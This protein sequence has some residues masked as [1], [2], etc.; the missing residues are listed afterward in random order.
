MR[1]TAVVEKNGD[2]R[3]TGNGCQL[4]WGPEDRYLYK[5]DHGGKQENALFK[6]DAQTLRPEKW[7]DAVGPFSHEYFPKIGN[8]ADV[9]VYGASEGGHEHDTAD[10]EIFLWLIGQPASTAVRISYHTGNDCWP[11]IFLFD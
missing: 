11:D 7:F 1:A 3:E 6:I 5:I 9:L 4:S 10:Y 8:R 2:L